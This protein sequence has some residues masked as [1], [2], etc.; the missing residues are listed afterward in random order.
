MRNS[1]MLYTHCNIISTNFSILT[2]KN[3]FT[4]EKTLNSKKPD[5]IFFYKHNQ[6][7]KFLKRKGQNNMTL[8]S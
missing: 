4:Y 1:D 8:L 3:S 2:E 7:N 5:M 6:L